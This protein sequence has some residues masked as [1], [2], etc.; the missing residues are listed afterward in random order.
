VHHD[1]SRACVAHSVDA[2]PRVVLLGRLTLYGPEAARLH[3]EIVPITARWVD[4]VQRKGALAPYG[5][6]A[7]GRALQVLE[8]ALLPR[9]GRAVEPVVAERLRASVAR[10]VEELLPRLE[11]RGETYAAEA[12]AK[13]T[14]RGR[15]ESDEMRKI[16][17]EQMRRLQRAA[18]ERD[19]AQLSLTFDAEE[20]RQV[21]SERRHWGKRLAELGAE[22]E[23]EPERIRALYEVRAQRVEPVGVVYLWPVTG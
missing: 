21:E 22:L 8:E 3:E 19:D 16:L 17:E 1:L 2:I 4:P 10:D 23:R 14:E 18:A 13:L 12:R 11:E 7:E 6:E 5:R 20:R 9:A 15:V